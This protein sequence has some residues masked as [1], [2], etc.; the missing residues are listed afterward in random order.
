MYHL[1]KLTNLNNTNLGEPQ[2]GL[3]T[4]KGTTV[5]QPARGSHPANMVDHIALH[6][7]WIP[8]GVVGLLTE[9]RQSYQGLG[10]EPQ[11]SPRVMVTMT[12][13]GWVRLPKTIDP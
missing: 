5:H 3:R 4:V 1:R 6:G 9:V 2:R 12:G 8:I 13:R 7:Q 10:V 11:S